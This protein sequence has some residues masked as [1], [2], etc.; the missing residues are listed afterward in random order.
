MFGSTNLRIGAIAVFAA[1][2]PSLE[3]WA[4]GPLR[5]CP[6]F[7][8]RTAESELV[9]FMELVGA[10]PKD[11]EEKSTFEIVEV[12]KGGDLVR[13]G[14]KIS[15]NIWQNAKVGDE[16]WCTGTS[17][18]TI[19][20]DWPVP[21]SKRAR[22]Y[23]TRLPTLPKSG[24]DR[25]QFF[26]E[27]LGDEEIPARDAC[28]EFESLTYDQ[29]VE[30]KPALKRDQLLKWI[31]DQELVASRRRLVF[32]MLGICGN[33][34]DVPLLEEL[35]ASS[36]PRDR[37]ALDGLIA[38]YLH[39]HGEPA[40]KLIEEKY[41]RNKNATNEETFATIMAIRHYDQQ[42]GSLTREQLRGA[43]KQMLKRPD[44]ADLVMVDLIRWKD[45]TAIDEC[46]ELFRN[47]D[48]ANKYV[49]VV[50]ARYLLACPLPRAQELVK[51]CERI[52]PAAVKR[53]RIYEGQ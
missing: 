46:F 21:V 23:L 14:D 53:A 20:W 27:Y 51:E 28:D 45:W 6:T 47:A 36:D 39:L 31:R 8:E 32:R 4:G 50:A 19:A 49:R 12:L 17:R 7:A 37:K 44:L 25:Y 15:V 24:P 41:L 18:P 3:L 42:K 35:L 13:V 9:V 43:L 5:R 40:L 29:L 30:L 11:S 34:D 38:C 1:L 2:L 52:E 33:N 16:F 22:E 48:P 10:V 26:F